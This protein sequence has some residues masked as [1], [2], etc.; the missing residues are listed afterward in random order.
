[1]E[2]STYGIAA[3][4]TKKSAA[5]I[6]KLTPADDKRVRQEALKRGVPV[7]ELVRSTVLSALKKDNVQNAGQAK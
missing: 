6:F 3:A 1:M 7:S 5:I 2:R 4:N